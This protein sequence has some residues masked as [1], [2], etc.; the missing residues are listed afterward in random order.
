MKLTKQLIDAIFEKGNEQVEIAVKLYKAVF[1][2]W[3]EIESIDNYPRVNRETSEY[4][5]DKFIKF[6]KSNHPG[7]MPGGLWMNK[8]FGLSE[9]DGLKFGEMDMSTCNPVYK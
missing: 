7:V 9:K 3:D 5:F 2:K 1:P 4:L 6:D 8:G